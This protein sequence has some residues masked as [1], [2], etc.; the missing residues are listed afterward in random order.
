MDQVALSYGQSSLSMSSTPCWSKVHIILSFE[1]WVEPQSDSKMQSTTKDW[2][3][4]W[5]S[6]IAPGT[7]WLYQLLFIITKSTHYATSCQIH[8]EESRAWSYL[9][10]WWVGPPL[11][12][13]QVMMNIHPGDHMPHGPFKM[14]RVDKRHWSQVWKVEDNKQVVGP[15]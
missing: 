7:Q 8:Q 5:S 11:H 10:I 12:S 2:C 9:L 3:H 4:I 1:P 15:T 13:N 6:I 14:T